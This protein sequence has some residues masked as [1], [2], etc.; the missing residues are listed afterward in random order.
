MFP[1]EVGVLGHH[2]GT[3]KEPS[4]EEGAGDVLEGQVSLGT[5]RGSRGGSPAA[6]L[7]PAR[8]RKGPLN[9]VGKMRFDG[10]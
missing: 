7:C 6:R 4:L 1:L 9:K 8:T 5:R 10:L 2:H 3:R